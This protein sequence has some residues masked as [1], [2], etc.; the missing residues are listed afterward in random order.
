MEIKEKNISVRGIKFFI[1]KEG[2]EIARAFL[3]LLKNELHPEPFGFLE[4]VFVEEKFRGQGIGT[5]LVRKVIEVAEKRG[6]YK[7]IATS[8]HSRP[9]VH[10]LYKRLGF[11]DYG[12]EFRIDFK[13]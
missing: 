12:L 1:E 13:T 7:L 4:D 11:K 8:R 2:K 3:Y 6:C 5:Q 10:L 9:K